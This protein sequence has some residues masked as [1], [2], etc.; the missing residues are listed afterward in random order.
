MQFL[1]K[2]PKFGVYRE[3]KHK[4]FID[5]HTYQYSILFFAIMRYAYEVLKLRRNVRMFI[6]WPKPVLDYAQISD[7][8][9]DGINHADYPDYVDAFITSATYMGR[10]MSDSE[11]D[12]LNE[13]SDFVYKQVNAK[14]Y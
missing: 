3:I 5:F 7:I 9:I 13:D 4:Y 2:L 6:I 1:K 10:P 14:I 8:E 12:V 11:L